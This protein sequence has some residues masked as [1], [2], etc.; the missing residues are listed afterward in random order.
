MD[1]SVAEPENS[2]FHS[3]MLSEESLP[4][5]RAAYDTFR[6]DL[7]ESSDL[8]IKNYVNKLFVS[9]WNNN[10]F[11]DIYIGVYAL[12]LLAGREVTA[13]SSSIVYPSH[14]KNWGSRVRNAG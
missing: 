1:S 9:N 14:L 2:R 10:E 7:P 3:F 13:P 4:T 5:L 12:S 6:S 11:D 8:L